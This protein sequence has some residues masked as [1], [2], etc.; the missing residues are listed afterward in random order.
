MQLNRRGLFKTLLGACAAPFVAKAL[1]VAEPNIVALLEKRISDAS[2]EMYRTLAEGVGPLPTNRI[3]TEYRYRFRA[4]G[5][6]PASWP[7]G[8][9][10]RNGG[11]GKAISPTSHQHDDSTRR[12]SL[13]LT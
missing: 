4:S 7:C 11:V 9:E 2:A 3:T 12:E 8:N 10:F 6:D 13:R 1:P 5:H